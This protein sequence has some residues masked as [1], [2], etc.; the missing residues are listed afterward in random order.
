VLVFVAVRGDKMRAIRRAI[1]GDFAVGAATDGAD[2]LSL[3]GAE[4][5]GFAFFTDRTGHEIS[6]DSKDSSAEYAAPRQKTKILLEN[7]KP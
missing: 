3:G 4:T 2:F 7:F 6:C 1:D 5:L